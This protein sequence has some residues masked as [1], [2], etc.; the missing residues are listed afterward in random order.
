M[1]GIRPG[2]S[3]KPERLFQIIC[4]TNPGVESELFFFPS[5]NASTFFFFLFSLQL[6]FGDLV[7]AGLGL[8]QPW[9]FLHLRDKT[10]MTAFLMYLGVELA[11]LSTPDPS[12]KWA[13]EMTKHKP[14]QGLLRTLAPLE[15]TASISPFYRLGNWGSE[16]RR[17]FSKATQGF[18]RRWARTDISWTSVH[19][20]VK[21]RWVSNL[22][23]S[24]P[25]KR[26]IQAIRKKELYSTG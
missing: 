6:S 25:T 1:P 4:Y 23:L 19:G 12:S 2:H 7:F 3:Y 17:G 20:F 13:W 22:H 16:W 11:P 9:I 18:Q 21:D 10:Q 5:P 8:C 26:P 14:A 24:V 15:H